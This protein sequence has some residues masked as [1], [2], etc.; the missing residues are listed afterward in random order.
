MGEGT[1]SGIFIVLIFFL[2]PVLGVCTH[3]P[4]RYRY[5]PQVYPSIVNGGGKRV[6]EG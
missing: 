3:T 2:L 5:G 4:K 1:G 6:Q